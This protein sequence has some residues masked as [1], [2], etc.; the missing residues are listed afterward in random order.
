MFDGLV[1]FYVQNNLLTK[2]SALEKSLLFFKDMTL[3]VISCSFCLTAFAHAEPLAWKTLT[4][5]LFRVKLYP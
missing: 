1:P 5:P 2:P 3:K 4:P